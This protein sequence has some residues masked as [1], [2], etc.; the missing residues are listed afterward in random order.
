MRTIIC[1]ILACGCLLGGPITPSSYVATPGTSGTCGYT[2]NTGTQLTDGVLG[3][4]YVLANLGNGCAYEWVAWWSANPQITFSFAGTVSIDTVQIGFARDAG[5]I[6][7]LPTNVDI[8]GTSFP[9]TGSEVGQGLRGWLTFNGSW[10]G[11]SLTFNMTQAQS[12]WIFVDE[13][14]FS[15]TADTA[16]PEPATTGMVALACGALL[17][18]TRRRKTV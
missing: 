2:D 3:S 11:S 15:S 16:V 4:N 12:T 13:I 8:G 7:Y 9:L 1:L 14:T 5:N 10:T 17:F 18:V 6:V